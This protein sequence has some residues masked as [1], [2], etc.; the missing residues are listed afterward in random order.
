[1]CE[2]P[3]AG[4]RP[5]FVGDD[6]TDEPAFEWMN[7]AGGLSVAVNAR[8]PTAARTQLRSVGEVRAWLHGLMRDPG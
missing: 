6:A 7:A 3:F 4:R 1:M 8:R 5:L 2:H